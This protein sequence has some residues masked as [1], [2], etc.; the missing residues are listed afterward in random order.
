MKGKENNLEQLE[1]EKTELQTQLEAEQNKAKQSKDAFVKWL[2]N[3]AEYYEAQIQGLDAF[4]QLLHI[5]ETQEPFQQLR[6]KSKEFNTQVKELEKPIEITDEIKKLSELRKEIEELAGK[7]PAYAETQVRNLA[8]EK[9]ALEA[10]VKDLETK[11]S[12]VA[13][14]QQKNKELEAKNKTTQQPKQ[15]NGARYTATVGMGL[16]AGLVGIYCT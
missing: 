5:K 7:L 10:K 13:T 4:F 12:D 15:G 1:K 11:N 9:A 6:E 8:E 3:E 2:Q 16:A 14:L